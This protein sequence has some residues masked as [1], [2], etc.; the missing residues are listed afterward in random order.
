ME[1]IL[2]RE[3]GNNR[4]HIT[5]DNKEGNLGKAGSVPMSVSR[6]HCK[7]TI[8]AKGNYTLTNLKPTNITYV[9]GLQIASK[10]ITPNDHVELGSDRYQLN[11]K[12]LLEA[13]KKS[14]NSNGGG[15]YSISHLQKVWEEYNTAK[16]N[17]QIQER[18]ANAISSIT[19]LFSMA[20][21]ALGFIQ[22]IP[23]EI[24]VLL[25]AVAIALAVYFF[26]ARYRSSEAMPKRSAEID[27][28]FHEQ[29]VCPNPDCQ[30]FLGYQPYD[31]LKKNIG[32]PQCK[33]K[34]V[35]K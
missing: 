13:V 17:M 9:N 34:Y 22:G 12:E 21:I 32:C 19:G 26:V 27:K 3:S 20:S 24:R 33:A 1:I 31:D 30:K 7:L 10:H 4:L 16:L 5:V 35:E 29:Y 14:G 11:L 8:D 6:Q 25:Y 2:G 15:E 28:K 18:R 23:T